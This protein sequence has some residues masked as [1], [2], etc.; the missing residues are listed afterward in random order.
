VAPGD[1]AGIAAAL[2]DMTS[3][4]DLRADLGRAGRA[5]ALRDFDRK[6]IADRFIHH[7]ERH[8]TC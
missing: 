3:S 4:A 7:L 5:A 1:I 6:D 8:R 2:R